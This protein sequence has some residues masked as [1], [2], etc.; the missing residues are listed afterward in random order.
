MYILAFV[1]FLGVAIYG[2]AQ[3]QYAITAKNQVGEIVDRVMQGQ[4]YTFTAAGNITGQ[5]VTFTLYTK[6]S[7]NNILTSDTRTVTPPDSC[8]ETECSLSFTIPNVQGAVSFTAQIGNSENTFTIISPES[9]PS[10]T[11]VLT[12]TPLPTTAAVGNCMDPDGLYA[13][14]S[15]YA[16][17]TVTKGSIAKKDACVDEKTIEEYYCDAQGELKSTKKECML[18]CIDGVCS[19]PESQCLGSK[20]PTP[21]VGNIITF[22]FSGVKYEDYCSDIEGTLMNQENKGEYVTEYVCKEGGG[23]DKITAECLWGCKDGACNIVPDEF[24]CVNNGKGVSLLKPKLTTSQE[25][26]EV[27]DVCF[28]LDLA[29]GLKDSV[30]KVSCSSKTNSL[31]LVPGLFLSSPVALT[32]N[33]GL[34]NQV[35][36]RN[37]KKCQFG[38]KTSTDGSGECLGGNI[39]EYPVYY[40]EHAEW[41]VR[42]DNIL[43]AKSF[44][45]L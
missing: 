41:S 20:T 38:C 11:P 26:I 21:F 32:I 2:L 9:S 24:V 23:V 43:P 4:A 42:S 12:S 18:G 31:F 35:I 3:T 25:D 10:I 39:I 14:N 30:V 45:M 16:V 28:G 13:N 19:A 44:V 40:Q 37:V 15:I 6:D 22:F 29:G 34:A 1:L 5:G 27:K 7:Q 36:E 17:N 33:S 8:T